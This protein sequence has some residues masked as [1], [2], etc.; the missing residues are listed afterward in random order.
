MAAEIMSPIASGRI[1]CPT[2]PWLSVR[3]IPGHCLSPDLATTLRISNLVD[4]PSATVGCWLRRQRFA[5]NDGK[6][7][8]ARAGRMVGCSATVGLEARPRQARQCGD[9]VCG[10]GAGDADHVFR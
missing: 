1:R 3:S 9:R 5:P 6:T 10:D 8:E 4:Q 2:T 7:H